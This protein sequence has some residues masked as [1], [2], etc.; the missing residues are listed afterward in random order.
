MFLFSFACR[1]CSGV[2]RGID[3]L[4]HAL[5][6]ALIAMQIL[7]AHLQ[8]AIQRHIHHLLVLQASCARFAAP[9]RKS[10]LDRGS[11]SLLQPRLILAQRRR[12][13][14]LFDCANSA[15]S[16]ASFTS[17][18]AAGTSLRKKF[19]DARQ[20]LQRDFSKYAWRIFQIC[21]A[22]AAAAPASGVRA[23]SAPPASPPAMRSCAPSAET[24]SRSA[25]TN[26]NP[27][28]AASLAASPV[29]NRANAQSTAAS[30]D[31]PVPSATSPWRRA[32]SIRFS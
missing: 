18:N 7:H 31:R 22:P 14:P 16:F 13:P 11:R 6:F 8:Q 28:S 23:Q 1:S 25:P 5:E 19:D 21:C 4:C 27:D 15:C 32:P 17:L 30:R 26:S 12:P 29:E 24:S 3:Q 2:L 20:L 9:S 10:P